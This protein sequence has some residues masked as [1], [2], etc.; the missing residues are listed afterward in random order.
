[1]DSLKKEPVVG[2]TVRFDY[3]V[4]HGSKIAFFSYRGAAMSVKWLKRDR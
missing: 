3:V 4:L 2:V 1:M